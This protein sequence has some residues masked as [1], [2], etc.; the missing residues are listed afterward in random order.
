MGKENKVYLQDGSVVDY[1]VL[2]INVGSKTRD[3]QNVEGVEEYGLT[4][5]PIN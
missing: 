1:D 4:T 3:S 2:V 5:R